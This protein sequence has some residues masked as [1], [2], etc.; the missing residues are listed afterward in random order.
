MGD[1]QRGRRRKRE[2]EEKRNEPPSPNTL[3]KFNT[4]VLSYMDA[5][6]L[7]AGPA[8]R[9]HPPPLPPVP[10]DVNAGTVED[11]EQT[12]APLNPVLH[13]LCP[14]SRRRDISPPNR[15]FSASPLQPE[16]VKN[17]HRDIFPTAADS[18]CRGSPRPLL[19]AD[20]LPSRRQLTSAGR[21]EDMNW[22]PEIFLL[23]PPYCGRCSAINSWHGRRRASPRARAPTRLPPLPSRPRRG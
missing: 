7:H 11:D 1:S 5:K 12:A 17:G 2:K 9:I 22:P 4:S 14:S 18:L 10:R 16:H 8:R 21:C 20:L 19:L 15:V 23:P 13:R 6:R 3:C